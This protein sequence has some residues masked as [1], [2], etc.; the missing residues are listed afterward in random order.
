LIREI[1]PQ[2]LT[3][4]HVLNQSAT[5][6]EIR[7]AFLLISLHSKSNNLKKFSQ[8]SQFVYQHSAVSPPSTTSIEALPSHRTEN[9]R[10]DHFNAENV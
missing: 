2:F 8:S 6:C 10:M 4:T 9:V 1:D 5:L 7:L 3:L